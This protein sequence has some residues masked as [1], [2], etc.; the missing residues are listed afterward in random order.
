M[1][2][3][4]YFRLRKTYRLTALFIAVILGFAMYSSAAETSSE[5]DVFQCNYV[6][7]SNGHLEDLKGQYIG[8]EIS[9]ADKLVSQNDNFALYYNQLAAEVKVEDRANGYVWTSAAKEYEGYRLSSTWKR[10]SKAILVIE[11]INRKTVKSKQRLPTVS[12]EGY[13][14]RYYDSG[15]EVDVPFTEVGLTITVNFTLTDDGMTVSIPDSSIQAD[16]AV[17][18]L[19]SKMYVL[20]FFGSAYRDTY[21]GYIFI[22]DGCGALMRFAKPGAY[23]NPYEER[24]YGRDYSINATVSESKSNLKT[25]YGMIVEPYT[26]NMP[27]FGM[28]HG[29]DQN[30]FLARIATG[31]EYC[32][33]K[34]SPAGVVVNYFWCAPQFIFRE[35]YWIADHT[36]FG[37]D[38]MQ[39]TTNSVNAEI[40]YAFLSN[41]Q[42]NYVGMANKYRQLLEREGLFP[43][44]K[45]TNSGIPLYLDAFMSE[46]VK[47]LI[48]TRTETL[49]EIHDV[50]NWVDILTGEGVRN[51]LVSLRGIEPGG[52]SGRDPETYKIASAIGSSK[53]LTVLY[54]KLESLNGQLMIS[55]NYTQLYSGQTAANNYVYSIERQYTTKALNAP[56]FDRMWFLDVQVAQKIVSKL[57]SKPVYYKNL[58][59]EATAQYLYSNYKANHEYTRDEALIKTKTLLDDASE[60]TDHLY[61]Q[62]PNEY[63]F[64][65]ADGIYGV[66]LNHSG[67]MFETDCVPFYQIVM[68]GSVPLFAKP[69]NTDI[70]NED[71]TLRLIEFNTY[72]I[73]TITEESTS[74]LAKSNSHDVFNSQADKM[75]PA[76]LDQYKA[77][78]AVL[79]QTQGLVIESRNV[80]SQGVVIVGY[81]NNTQIIVNYTDCEY[82]YL[83]ETI[84]AKAAAVFKEGRK[85]G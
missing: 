33:I 4:M 40:Q 18:D 38:V 60:A 27:V 14:T 76:M 16:P 47:A 9:P 74:V 61:L 41:E 25:E 51:L 8:A 71:T 35:I 48:G 68:S 54:D 82:K 26:V 63:A 83:G 37:F 49:T 59:I 24:I 75:I 17:D 23:R 42:A 45:E 65:Y 46:T 43:E 13:V 15:F 69:M 77:V 62:R 28:A 3:T 64:P 10:F 31:A 11:T 7:S 29:A 50:E 22:P 70:G 34:A 21:P 78:N 5:Y 39:K 20:P 19:L 12:E 80:V 66:P 52:Y 44:K 30:A 57:G 73:Y 72:P 53:E 56:L 2:D 67:Y 84:G 6:N 32:N 36:G 79:S 1:I 55:K 58:A 81:E 85:M